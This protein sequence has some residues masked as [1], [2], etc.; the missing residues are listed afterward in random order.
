MHLDSRIKALAGTA[1][2]IGL[3]A[4]V[5][6]GGS[7]SASPEAHSAACQKAT[8]IEAIIDDSGSMFI[9][10]P[11]KFRTT[12]LDAFTALQQN[13]GKTLGGIEFGNTADVLFAPAA[14]PGVI[15]A[16]DASFAAVNAD[17]GTTD[18]NLAFATANTA[19]PG[20]DGRI[21]LSDGGHDVGTY[22]NGHASPPTKTDT[23]GFGSVDTTLLDRI[24]SDTGGKSFNLTDSSQVPAIAA[25]VTADMNCKAPPLT[26]TDN[27]TH[28]GQSFGHAFKVK[29]KS[30]DILETWTDQTAVLTVTGFS[31]AGGHKA[32]TSS[33]AHASVKARK[34]SGKGFVT[35]HLK[36]LKKGTRIRFKVKAKQLA[37]PT[38]ATA[39][40]IR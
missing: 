18:Y 32:S 40:V 12:L 2:L 4:A 3:L 29:G 25:A 36:G 33:V 6:A 38:T 7:A 21:F 37:G 17:N 30:A 10:D 35:V 11:N 1:S 22:N 23:V 8:N 15:P 28:Q 14:I 16:M 31:T 24:A 5:A 19:N 20:A 26:F 13:Q 9:T 27:F 34:K 39:S